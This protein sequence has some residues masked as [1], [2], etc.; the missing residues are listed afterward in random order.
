M[1]RDTLWCSMAE[2]CAQLISMELR[3]IDG[4]YH[5]VQTGHMSVEGLRVLSQIGAI[6][7]KTYKQHCDVI[8]ECVICTKVNSRDKP[9]QLSARASDL[10]AWQGPFG[11]NGTSCYL[12]GKN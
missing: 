7:Y 10:V 1:T 4:R 6:P 12:K 2:T 8:R 3:I 5:H 9:T 11:R